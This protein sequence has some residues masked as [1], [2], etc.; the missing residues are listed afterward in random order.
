MSTS[1]LKKTVES[2]QNCNTLPTIATPLATQITF[3]NCENVP[4][5][6]T[7]V[8]QHCPPQQNAARVIK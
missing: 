3:T 6:F 4:L 8:L 5:Q 1:D 2:E 7:T